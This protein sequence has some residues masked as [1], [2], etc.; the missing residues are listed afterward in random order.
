[1]IDPLATNDGWVDFDTSWERKVMVLYAKTYI[2]H[3]LK[4]NKGVGVG[5]GSKTLL[6][7]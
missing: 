1:M 3:L 7:H 6:A 4:F 2:F 5:G